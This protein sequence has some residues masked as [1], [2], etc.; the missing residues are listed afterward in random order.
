MNKKTE[1]QLVK[2]DNIKST[3]K[4]SM[5]RSINAFVVVNLN[6]ETIDQKAL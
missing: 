5:E 1:Q 2:G 6:I 4:I 3:Q